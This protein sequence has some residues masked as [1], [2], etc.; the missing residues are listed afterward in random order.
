MGSKKEAILKTLLYSDLFDY[1]LTEEEIYQYLIF[2]KIDKDQLSKLLENTNLHIDRL[3]NFFFLKGRGKIVKARLMKKKF[4]L[5]KLE[6][7]KK[8][9]K[10]LGLI[11]TIKL[12]GISGTLAV[13]N[14]KKD[15]DIDIFVI[16]E[17]KLVWTT[18]F[19][20]AIMLIFLGVYRSK[21]ST[22]NNNKI[23]LN[24]LLD[25]DKMQFANYD[26]FTAHEIVQ[27]LPIFDRDKTYQKFIKANTWI[28]KIF[29]NFKIIN[30]PLIKKQSNLFDKLFIFICNNLF[31]EIIFKTAQLFYMKKSI[32]RERLEDDFIGLHPFD[33]KS[34]VLR[35]YNARIS[36]FSLK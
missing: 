18:R 17:N 10:F 1:P 32:T 20:T 15:D 3:N 8:I 31:I 7:A 28:N 21:N 22:A 5:E 26:L 6:K 25:E 23:C 14:C 13:M 2:Q 9:I 27:L 24:L 29:P 35:K 4:S 19:F 30:Q 16:A 36:K 11:P 12:I 33:Y 34:Y